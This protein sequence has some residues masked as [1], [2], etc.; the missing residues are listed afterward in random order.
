MIVEQLSQ[1]FTERHAR[2]ASKTIGTIVLQCF[3]AQTLELEGLSARLVGLEPI[4]TF[5]AWDVGVLLNQASAG[6][7]TDPAPAKL[8]WSLFTVSSGVALPDFNDALTNSVDLRA[9]GNVAFSAV[10]F[11]IGTGGFLLV[12]RTVDV[13]V[14]GGG[15][16]DPTGNPNSLDLKD[17]PMLLLSLN[18]VDIFVGVGASLDDNNTPDTFADDEI[19]TTDAIG[20]SVGPFVNDSVRWREFCFSFLT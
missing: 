12:N 6:V 8:N 11:L 5:G 16:S 4:L 14:D 2:Y 10:D 3:A 9:E 15:I 13:D 7:P 18:E 20:F 1:L 19:V 17:A